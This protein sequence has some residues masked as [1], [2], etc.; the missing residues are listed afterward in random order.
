M[1]PPSRK[2]SG[3]APNSPPMP[4]PTTGRMLNTIAVALGPCSAARVAAAW[5]SWASI[6]RW[7]F[8]HSATSGMPCRAATFQSCP[9]RTRSGQEELIRTLAP[10]PPPAG[11]AAATHTA[12]STAERINRHP[13][14]VRHAVPS[15]Q[16]PDHEP[17]ERAGV[18]AYRGG[19]GMLAR[20]ADRPDDSPDHQHRTEDQAHRPFQQDQQQ[21]G[22]HWCFLPG[23][24]LRNAMQ[25]RGIGHEQRARA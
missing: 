14:R 17:Q 4:I 21:H 16:V 12:C 2:C 3:S 10:S 18:R 22:K 9:T 25:R 19:S 5:V 24:S 8:S 23:L 13:Q 1:P 7:A 15:A 20:G 11:R 6:R